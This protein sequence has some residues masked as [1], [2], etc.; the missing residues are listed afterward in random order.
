METVGPEAGAVRLSL[1]T[2]YEMRTRLVPGGPRGPFSGR[3][4]SDFES[5]TRRHILSGEYGLTE[6]ISILGEMSYVFIDTDLPEGRFSTEG[7]GDTS[8][9]GRFTFT[10]I[11]HEHVDG[12]ELGPFGLHFGPGRVAIAAGLSFPT[13]EPERSATS[14]EPIPNSALQTGTGTFDP[15]VSA[16][17]SQS[18][19]TGSVF[20]GLSVRIPGGENRFDYETGAAF[21]STLG[22]TI[23]ASDDVEIVPKLAYLYARPDEFEGKST[24]ASGG[25]VVSIVPGV[26]IAL[27][28]GKKAHLELAVDV[29]VYRDF[30]TESLQPIARF[31]AGI[32]FRF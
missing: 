18:V 21:H 23:P 17:F 32:T 4:D 27:D 2:T 19:E 11:P 3:R 5:T 29:P 31:E 10:A 1:W 12:E 8:L 13:G 28:D 14:G 9:L 24:F 16:A 25:H 30:R 26:R 20:A 22:G 7:L 15:L 6:S